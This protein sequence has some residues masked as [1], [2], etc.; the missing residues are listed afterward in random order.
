MPSGS[1]LSPEEIFEPV[2]YQK[3]SFKQGKVRLLG[4][5]KGFGVFANNYG[6]AI[7]ERE[8]DSFKKE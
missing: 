6:M 7:V 4:A 8:V 1:G 5:A 2:A 3:W